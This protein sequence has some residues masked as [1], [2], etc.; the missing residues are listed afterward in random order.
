MSVRITHVRLSSDYYADHE[1]ITDF[2]WIGY[3]D[4]K[5][6]QSTKGAM[7][8]WI[9]GGG[10]AYVESTTTKVAVGGVKPQNGEPYLRTYANGVWTDNL[11]S[12][13]RF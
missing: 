10:Q 3:E 13:P 6:G 9:N 8:D 7:V 12:L 4:G 5:T 1:H 2:K 11:L